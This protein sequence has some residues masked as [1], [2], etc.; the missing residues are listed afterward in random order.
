MPVNRHECIINMLILM[1]N[2]LYGAREVDKPEKV[3]LFGAGHK[4]KTKKERVPGNLGKFG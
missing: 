3:N 2:I 1:N 4:M